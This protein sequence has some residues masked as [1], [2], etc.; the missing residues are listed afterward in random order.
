[1]WLADWIFKSQRVVDP[2]KD[3]GMVLRVEDQFGGD[4][5]SAVLDNPDYQFILVAYD[6][7]QASREGFHKILPL[8]K[9]AMAD[10]YSFIC[11][12]NSLPAEIKKFRM[13]NGTAFDYYNSDDVVLKTMV[14]SNPGL[15]LL[16]DGIV[17]GKWGFRDFPSYE[18]LKEGVM[19]K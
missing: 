14:R 8:F 11:L 1:V 16:K 19:K 18:D 2:N 4:F 12:T 9:K 6:L 10:G 7:N 15:I 3:Q 13:E 17:I 5:T